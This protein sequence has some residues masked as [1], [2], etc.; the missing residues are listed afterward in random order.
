VIG[1]RGGRQKMKKLPRIVTQVMAK[2]WL[3]KELPPRMQQQYKHGNDSSGL[4]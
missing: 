3:E 2:E 1:K 4:N